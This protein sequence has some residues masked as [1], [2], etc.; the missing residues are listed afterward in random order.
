MYNSVLGTI[1]GAVA[2]HQKKK[3]RPHEFENL[4]TTPYLHGS[5]Y[6]TELMGKAKYKHDYECILEHLYRH[7]K[8]GVDV[9]EIESYANLESTIIEKY[10]RD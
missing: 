10:R 9:L 8:N 5:E 6:L 7:Q 4:T 2:D 3:Y 1:F